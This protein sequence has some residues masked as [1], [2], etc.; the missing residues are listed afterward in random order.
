MKTRVTTAM[1]L[2]QEN[3]E[4][5]EQFESDS[6]RKYLGWMTALYEYS[7]NEGVEYV[8]FF[9]F[10]FDAAA[11]LFVHEIISVMKKRDFD[12]EYR[13]LEPGKRGFNTV[14]PIDQAEGN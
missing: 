8:V 9:V 6:T 11:R 1:V 10:R 7:V 2:S 14:V 13:W 3:L 4:F 12:Q 5:V